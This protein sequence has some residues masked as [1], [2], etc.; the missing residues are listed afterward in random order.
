MGPIHWYSPGLL[1]YCSHS[2]MISHFPQ[3]IK[4]PTMHHFGNRNV[5]IFVTKWCIVGCGL[6]HCGICATSL[7]S[8]CQWGNPEIVMTWKHFPHYWPFVNGNHQWPV[9]F[10]HKGTVVRNIHVLF[11]ISLNIAVEQ[12]VEFLM[13]WDTIMLMWSHSNAAIT[14][15]NFNPIKLE[16]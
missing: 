1:H 7:L 10:P 14:K 6:L 15:Q 2:H 13:I 16:Y 5:H 11:I 3:C 4:C 12:M 9:D 8:Q